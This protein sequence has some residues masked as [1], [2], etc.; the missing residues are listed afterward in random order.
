MFLS[1]KTQD[2]GRDGCFLKHC[3]GKLMNQCFRA[4]VITQVMWIQKKKIGMVH[5][6]VLNLGKCD[7][8]SIAIGSID[9]EFG[10]S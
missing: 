1:L 6:T 3:F 8:F 10:K 4:C 2:A 9:S 5:H 7:S